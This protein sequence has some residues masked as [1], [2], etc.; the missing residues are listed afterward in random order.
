MGY[1]D[2]DDRIRDWASRAAEGQDMDLAE[3]FRTFRLED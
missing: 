1:L 2:I 3:A